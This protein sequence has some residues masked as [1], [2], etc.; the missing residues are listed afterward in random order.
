MYV[1]FCS[2]LRLRILWRIKQ[3]MSMK[4]RALRVTSEKTEE[5]FHALL[6][7]SKALL[8]LL[9]HASCF[10]YDCKAIRC[11]RNTLSQCHMPLCTAFIELPIWYAA[12][13]HV[14]TIASLKTATK[15]IRLQSFHI[16]A[17]LAS[18]HPSWHDF[19]GADGSC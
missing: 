7:V 5:A 10:C 9:N 1:V 11:V 2:S 14:I 6:L 3:G 12:T 15:V 16:T 4:E 8:A 17:A 13:S 18:M 19:W